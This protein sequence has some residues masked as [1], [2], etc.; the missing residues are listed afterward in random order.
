MSRIR[1]LSKTFLTSPKYV[2]IN[3]NRID[4]VASLLQDKHMEI[5]HWDSPSMYIQSDDFE[6][7]C[8]YYLI[9]NAIN[10][11][12][13]DQDRK[14]FQNKDLECSILMRKCLTRAWKDIKDPLFLASIDETYLLG[15]LLQAEGPISLVKERTKALREVG[16]FLNGNVNFT[17]RKLF[18]KHQEN[19]YRVSQYIPFLLPTWRDP[20]CKRAQLFV[21]MVYGRF[22]DSKDLPITNDSLLDLTVFADYRVPETLIRMGIII[23]SAALKTKLHRREFIASGSRKELELRAATIVAA[24]LLIE[25]INR[26]NKPNETINSLQMDSL[27]WNIGKNIDEILNDVL[28][29]KHIVHHFTITTDY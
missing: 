14:K 24:D 3:N 4:E 22:Q 11:C 26:Y 20:F 1:K 8:K 23:P 6:E 19:A 25:A 15:E 17:F 28:I 29:E 13:F 21:A 2:K 7:M 10:Y 18:E 9:F 5:P 27:L 12:Y 16:N